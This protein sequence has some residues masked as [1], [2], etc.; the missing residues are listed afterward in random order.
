M[1]LLQ[2]KYAEIRDK[3]R[4]GDII[5]FGGKG[6]FSEIIKWATRA[7]VSH[8]CIVLQSELRG[9]EDLGT[10][11]YFNQIIEST[12]LNGFSGVTIS[13]LSDSPSIMPLAR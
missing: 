8:V 1:P 10:D 13:R 3:V 12:S 5:A 11:G 6:N 2:R 9:A 7:S 4:A